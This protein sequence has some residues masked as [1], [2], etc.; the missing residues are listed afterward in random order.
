[1]SKLF[2][3]NYPVTQK[4][5]NNF[6]LSNGQW[7]YGPGG[8][9]G[10]D[11]GTPTGTSVYAIANGKVRAHP[12]QANGF[13]RYVTLEFGKYIVV[14]AHLQRI[15][16]TGKVKA[17]KRIAKTDNTGFSTAPHFHLEVYEN[18]K[19]INPEILLKRLS[20]DKPK[21][22]R[23]YK[24]KVTAKALNVRTGPS[25]VYKIKNRKVKGNTFYVYRKV[26]GENISGKST[27]YK[28]LRGWVWG[29]GVKKVK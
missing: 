8:H 17:G 5:G 7:A 27:W 13:G 16:R 22:F 9:Q 10:I 3:E 25:T 28:T 14:Y 11:Y 2:K 19:L 26:K 24:V 29:G 23:P 6:R 15:T 21:T 18:R 4:F 12:F 1:M 20:A